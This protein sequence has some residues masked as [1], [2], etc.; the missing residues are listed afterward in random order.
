MLFQSISNCVE[1]M[2][3]ILSGSLYISWSSLMIVTAFSLM[4]LTAKADN[5]IITEDFESYSLPSDLFGGNGGSG[6]TGS[7][8]GSALFEVTNQGLPTQGLKHLSIQPTADPFEFMTRDIPEVT[9]GTLYVDMK[10]DHPGGRNNIGVRGDINLYED[11]KLLVRV[12]MRLSSS[13][14]YI[15]SLHWDGDSNEWYIATAIENQTYYRVGIQFDKLGQGNKYRINVD[16][17]VWS[18]WRSTIDNSDF[19]SINTL[20]L[21]VSN[22]DGQAIGTMYFDN[23]AMEATE[24]QVTI[25]D[26]NALLIK[27]IDAIKGNGFTK[28]VEQSYLAHLEKLI[29]MLDTADT[30]SVANQ[31]K[32]FIKKLDSDLKK[33]IIT[34]DI[35]VDLKTQ[36]EHIIDTLA[37][38][39]FEAPLM[40]QV[41]SPHPSEALTTTWASATYA[42]GRAS[43]TG[44]CGLTIKQCGCAISSLSMLGK[45]YGIDTGSDGTVVNP[46]NM[47][48]W[49]V[50]NNGYTD[51]GTLLWNSALTYLGKEKNGKK[52]SS[53]GLS[54]QNQTAPE[55]IATALRAKE[56]A[57]GFN[58]PKGHWMLLRGTTADGYYVNDPFWYNTKTTDDTKS[59]SGNVQDYDDVITKA[60]LFE[61]SSAPLALA[62]SLEVV[63]ESPAELLVT[64]SKGRRLGYVPETDTFVHEIPGGTYDR[65]DS[66]S[67]QENPSPNPHNAKRLMLVK[68]EG[69][70]FDLEVIG[71]GDGE[72]N[73][74]VVT[75]DGKGEL[76]NERASRM[77]SPG[78]IDAFTVTTLTGTVDLPPH[79]KNILNLIP[80]SE[81]KKFIQAFKVVFAQTEKGHMA[82]TEKL[83]QNL[84]TY[85][86]KQYKNDPWV[87]SVV[88]ALS[89][90]LP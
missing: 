45:Y 78:Q 22:Q 60:N 14:D 1:N 82:V 71:T 44:N 65:E 73:L 38:F 40:T 80:S 6:W 66:I 89:A 64:D 79:L 52:M 25:D 36:A 90:L 54:D 63:L 10:I 47:N 20:S 74:T 67:D 39:E 9:S 56:P 58:A 84:I 12:F 16:N 53:L 51:D 35:A 24:L 28:P 62:E 87:P 17:G 33:G 27:L 8:N 13:G 11:E 57:L 23:I 2:K 46:L 4:P 72:Y 68:P 75:V 34:E 18:E 83:I 59:I 76:T 3:N 85:I 48:N 77:T 31:L 7:W 29:E 55:V 43:T 32:A 15:E 70:V 30:Q 5:I 42:D 88:T 81:H 19:S 37:E 69:E 86:K 50:A 61:H 49:L 21:S 41:V 26:V